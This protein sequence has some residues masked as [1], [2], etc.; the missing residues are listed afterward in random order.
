MKIRSQCDKVLGESASKQKGFGSWFQAHRCLH[1]G[2][3]AQLGSQELKSGQT[4]TSATLQ[5]SLV[6]PVTLFVAKLP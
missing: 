1:A 6:L 3:E 5:V 2:N 4:V